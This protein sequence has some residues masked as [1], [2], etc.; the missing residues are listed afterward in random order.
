M[1]HD[2]WLPTTRRLRESYTWRGHANR[3]RGI[4]YELRQIL[5]QNLLTSFIA[6]PDEGPEMLKRMI[7][8]GRGIKEKK[9]LSK[10]KSSALEVVIDRDQCS[11]IK[12]AN[13]WRIAGELVRSGESNRTAK[14][15][16]SFQS[17][18]DSGQGEMWGI[19]DMRLMGSEQYI[20]YDDSDSRRFVFS[21]ENQF[22]SVPFECIVKPPSGVNPEIAGFRKVG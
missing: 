11:F 12:K 2:D 22:S 20:S 3:L 1:T 14:V 8:L 16:L 4:R 7:N 21:A 17:I 18:A 5:I 6:P 10:T 9:S 19:S 15:H 13:G